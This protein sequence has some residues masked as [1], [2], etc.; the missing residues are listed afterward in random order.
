MQFLI[1]NINFERKLFVTSVSELFET[2]GG[3]A[4][5]R[6]EHVSNGFCHMTFSSHYRMNIDGGGGNISD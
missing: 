3:I 2:F 6:M 5:K 1:D 4:G